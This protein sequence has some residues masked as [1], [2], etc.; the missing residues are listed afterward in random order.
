MAKH[1]G[2]VSQGI[3]PII[4]QVHPSQNG[5]STGAQINAKY[6]QPPQIPFPDSDLEKPAPQVYDKKL[7]LDRIVVPHGGE[8]F[9]TPSIEALKNYLPNRP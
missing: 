2:G 6:Q 3:D 4:G 9:F 8:Y 5:K 7:D 1:N